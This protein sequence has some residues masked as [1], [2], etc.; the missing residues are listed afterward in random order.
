MNDNFPASVDSAISDCQN[1][2]IQT[3]QNACSGQSKSVKLNCSESK[4]NSNGKLHTTNLTLISALNSKEKISMASQPVKMYRLI[5]S[6]NKSKV[7]N[8]LSNTMIDKENRL[9]GVQSLEKLSHDS[10]QKVPDKSSTS[11]QLPCPQITSLQSHVKVSLVVEDTIPNNILEE[12]SSL[13][14]KIVKNCLHSM[15]WTSD[16]DDPDNRKLSYPLTNSDT[17]HEFKKITIAKIIKKYDY[18]FD[19]VL[20]A[21]DDISHGHSMLSASNHHNVPYHRLYTFMK[22]LHAESSGDEEV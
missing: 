5:T 21:V 11:N 9:Y 8:S 13:S 17:A 15:D 10:L 22:E 2:A 12:E 14:S 20:C 18:D 1:L 16:V 6:E 4:Q 7:V 19:A 3:N